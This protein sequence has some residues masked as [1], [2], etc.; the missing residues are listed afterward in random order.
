MT[1][2]HDQ[3]DAMDYSTDASTNGDLNQAEKL[4]AMCNETA[5]KVCSRCRSIQY[6]SKSCQKVDWLV[7]KLLCKKFATLGKRPNPLTKRAIWFPVSKDE[8]QWVWLPYVENED[9]GDIPRFKAFQDK[10]TGFSHIQFVERCKILQRDLKCKLVVGSG[11]SMHLLPNRGI[12]ANTQGLAPIP[13]RGSVIVYGQLGAFE[14][15]SQLV[16]INMTDFK[17]IVE[18]F[19]AYKHT[20]CLLEHFYMS[21]NP[22]GKVEGVRINGNF[23]IIKHNAPKYQRL[24]VS[25]GHPL[26]MNPTVSPVSPI[27]SRL[28]LNIIISRVP[29]HRAVKYEVAPKVDESAMYLMFCC[30]PASEKGWGR[31]YK[32][33][34]EDI[35][36]VFVVRKDKKPLLPQHVEALI[37]FCEFKLKLYFDE[38]RE[39]PSP[40]TMN[41]ERVLAEIT[42][43][44]F[45]AF[46][47]EYRALKA[48]NMPEWANVPSPYEI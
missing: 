11:D 46:F 1:D 35:D 48:A 13:W 39:A 30:N 38:S 29:F 24:L 37:F 14:D 47:K 15:P 18:W 9:D 41:R 8:P 2:I 12:I 4:C 6:C 3:A 36:T 26:F 17:H 31:P 20:I 25:P 23:H 45:G 34:A 28:G 5:S 16:D 33:W 32:G 44:R 42:Q 43:E 10:E 40:I 7:H 27:S 22:P 19:S 21:N